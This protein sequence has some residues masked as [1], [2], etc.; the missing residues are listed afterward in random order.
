[1]KEILWLMKEIFWFEKQNNLVVEESNKL[2]KGVEQWYQSYVQCVI[3]RKNMGEK[4][5]HWSPKD[6][7]EIS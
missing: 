1:M 4:W 2:K 5:L 3:D 7:I 6:R